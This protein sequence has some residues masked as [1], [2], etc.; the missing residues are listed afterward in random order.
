MIHTRKLRRLY[1]ETVAVHELDLDVGAGEI[2]GFLGPN[3]AGK[4]TTVKIL[5]GMIKP[6][7]GEARVAGFDIVT[8][9]I[10]VKQRIGYVP[11]SSA[12]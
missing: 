11:E 10:E 1:G 8:Q 5:A 7:S 9:A 3:G 6:T 12:V 2:L 4:S